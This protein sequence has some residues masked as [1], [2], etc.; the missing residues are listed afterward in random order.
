MT[1][2]EIVEEFEKGC[3][4]GRPEDCPTCVR[5]FLNAL[6][7]SLLR[8]NRELQ[9]FRDFYKGMANNIQKMLKD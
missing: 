4:H 2:L 7:P 3:S 5:A 1:P 9:D 6:T 8:Q